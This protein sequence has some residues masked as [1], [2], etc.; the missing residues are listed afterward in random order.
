MSN[1]YDIDAEDLQ[2]KCHALRAQL[3]RQEAE[4]AA[5]ER[6]LRRGI[7]RLALVV[8]DDE[9]EASQAA[10]ALRQAIR[11]GDASRDLSVLIEN[12]SETLR[13]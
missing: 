7:S 12:L 3:E 6:L 4:Y 8:E 1:E 13:S 9:P 10:V 11:R 5:V 2:Q